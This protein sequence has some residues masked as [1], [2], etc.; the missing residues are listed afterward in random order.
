[1]QRNAE[2]P[3]RLRQM[4]C[5]L[6]AVSKVSI[7]GSSCKATGGVKCHPSSSQFRSLHARPIPSCKAAAHTGCDEQWAVDVHLVLIRSLPVHLGCRAHDLNYYRHGHRHSAVRLCTCCELVLG[8]A[9]GAGRPSK[10]HCS[11]PGPAKPKCAL[12]RRWLG[13]HVLAPQ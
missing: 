8:C 1:M 3:H 4:L 12:C 10:P 7:G 11:V 6:S 5:G 2:L 9:R 13:D